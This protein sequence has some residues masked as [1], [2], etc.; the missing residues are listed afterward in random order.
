MFVVANTLQALWHVLAVFYLL[1]TTA[2]I[3]DSTLLSWAL[4]V[5]QEAWGDVCFFLCGQ[6]FRQ[7]KKKC[8]T[9]IFFVAHHKKPEKERWFTDDWVCGVLGIQVSHFR[10]HSGYCPISK[11]YSRTRNNIKPKPKHA[12]LDCWVLK[13]KKSGS[14]TKDWV[15]RVSIEFSQSQKKP[16]NA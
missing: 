2:Q 15:Q 11:G 14:V 1:E 9:F 5:C 16:T 13:T 8:A 3:K 12:I 6:G 7:D 4:Y 10:Y